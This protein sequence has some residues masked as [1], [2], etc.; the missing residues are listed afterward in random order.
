M[1]AVMYFTI[2]NVT[3]NIALHVI[4]TSKADRFVICTI[5]RHRKKP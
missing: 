3:K 2:V 5:N 1:G 4:Q